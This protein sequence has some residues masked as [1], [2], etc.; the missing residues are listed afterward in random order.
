[1]RTGNDGRIPDAIVICGNQLLQ[2]Q[3]YMH[4]GDPPI[5]EGS[6]ADKLANVY[7]LSFALARSLLQT[8][9]LGRCMSPDM[10]TLF[11][12]LLVFQVIFA[13]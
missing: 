2:T 6:S 13:Y 12:C 4:L 1:M 5:Q 10:S 9:L 11:V 3:N 8:T 7:P